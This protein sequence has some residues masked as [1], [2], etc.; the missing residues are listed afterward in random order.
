MCNYFRVRVTK[1]KFSIN[2]ISSYILLFGVA[3]VQYINVFGVVYAQKYEVIQN[4]INSITI[5][6]ESVTI[7]EMSIKVRNLLPTG[8]LKENIQWQ[9]CTLHNVW[10]WYHSCTIFVWTLRSQ[11]SSTIYIPPG[12]SSTK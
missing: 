8:K 5:F 3:S 6:S 12:L 9:F 2:T 11:S 7:S 4:H 10:A 1:S